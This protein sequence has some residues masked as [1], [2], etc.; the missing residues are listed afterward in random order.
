VTGS[1]GWS[2]QGST[3]CRP[4]LTCSS[5]RPLEHLIGSPHEWELEITGDGPDFG[6][7][8]ALVSQEV[9]P[10]PRPLVWNGDVPEQRDDPARVRIRL[11]AG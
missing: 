8:G 11:V 10:R 3:A 1:S 2:T 6:D 9:D 7:Q 5:R 4:W